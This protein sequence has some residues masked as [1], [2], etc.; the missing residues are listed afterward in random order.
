MGSYVLNWSLCIRASILTTCEQHTGIIHDTHS[1]NLC[2]HHTTMH[3]LCWQ[4]KLP[5]RF[6]AVL[7]R[8]TGSKN[9][10][11]MGST[12]GILA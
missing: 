8:H 5:W 2:H 12:C 1:S 6:V 9:D 4:F 11:K 3:S 7:G 10:R